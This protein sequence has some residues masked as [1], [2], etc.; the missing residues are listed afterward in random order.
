MNLVRIGR[1]VLK[2]IPLIRRVVQNI[3]S[4]KGGKG[5]V[6]WPDLVEDILETAITVAITYFV[7]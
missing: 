1:F 6:I 4:E 3:E 7:S 2:T 5:K